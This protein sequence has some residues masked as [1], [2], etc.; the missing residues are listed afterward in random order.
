VYEEFR[1]VGL[2]AARAVPVARDGG[3]PASIDAAADGAFEGRDP[4]SLND[5]VY[6]FGLML[7]GQLREATVGRYGP[8]KSTPRTADK[9]SAPQVDPGP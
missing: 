6:Q 5:R 7:M 3:G 2:R 4:G 1:R 8:T 9:M